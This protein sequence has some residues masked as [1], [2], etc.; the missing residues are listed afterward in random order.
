MSKMLSSVLISIA[1]ML[2]SVT[3]ISVALAIYTLIDDKRLAVLFASAAVLLDVFKYLAWPV[4]VR[5]LRGSMSVLMIACAL[6]LSTVSGWATY[7]RLISSINMSKATHEAMSGG[8]IESLKL[9]AQKDSSLISQLEREVSVAT[10]QANDLRARGMAS[11]A[12][13]M[14]ESVSTRTSKQRQEALE[15]IN[16]ASLEIAQIES[17]VAKAANLPALLAQL[18]CVGF[19]MSLEIVPALI[20]SGI[21]NTKSNEKAVIHST[22]VIEPPVLETQETT[23]ETPKTEETLFDSNVEILNALVDQAKN[24]P[25]GTPIKLKDFAKTCRIGNLRAGEIFRNAE[26]IGVIKKTTIGYVSL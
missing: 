2:S 6:M 9:L 13:E 18:L 5:L 4:A 21:R 11:K 22:D 24:S 19:A 20:L 23:L 14:E 15:R 1:F 10:I 12:L 16:A 17:S 26:K 7:D 25:P 3:A 8:R